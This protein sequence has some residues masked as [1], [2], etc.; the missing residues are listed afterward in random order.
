MC[1][2]N[3]V[4]DTINHFAYNFAKCSSTLKTPFYQQTDRYISNEV[5]HRNLNAW[6]YYFVIYH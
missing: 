2:A 3:W 5:T 1:K 4:Y 6:L